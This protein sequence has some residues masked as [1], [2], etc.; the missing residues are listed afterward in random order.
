MGDRWQNNYTE[1]PILAL[2]KAALQV[3][4][5][6]TLCFRQ[7]SLSFYFAKDSDP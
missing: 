7:I 4:L 5:A 2:W 3:L 6:Q 1:T